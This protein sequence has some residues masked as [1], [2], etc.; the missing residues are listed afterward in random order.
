M[1]IGDVGEREGAK[2]LQRAAV[3]R[4]V[5]GEHRVGRGQAVTY[6]SPEPTPTTPGRG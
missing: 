3:E 1:S 2:L 5:V 4:Q 6:V